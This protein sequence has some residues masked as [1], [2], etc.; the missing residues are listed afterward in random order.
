MCCV[1]TMLGGMCRRVEGGGPSYQQKRG[2]RR[3]IGHYIRSDKKRASS[4]H[5]SARISGFFSCQYIWVDPPLESPPPP[6]I[7]FR[8]YARG[9]AHP[10]P[11][12]TAP[13]HTGRGVD[14]WI[15]VIR[16]HTRDSRIPHLFLVRGVR[17][18]QI[19]EAKKHLWKFFF[20]GKCTGTGKRKEIKM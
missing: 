18:S 2:G 14:S 11:T 15:H 4:S 20:R 10:A 16:T 12:P 1:C 17:V 5:T 19:L 3:W 8:S 7:S 6:R 9:L 13:A